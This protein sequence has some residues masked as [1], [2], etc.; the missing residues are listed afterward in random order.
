MSCIL[1]IYIHIHHPILHTCIYWLAASLMDAASPRLGPSLGNWPSSRL[2]QEMRLCQSLWWMHWHGTGVQQE[3]DGAARPLQ[4]DSKTESKW[5]VACLSMY[6]DVSRCPL[7]WCSECCCK[8]CCESCCCGNHHIN[9]AQERASSS[10]L[11]DDVVVVIIK[12]RH[13]C[14]LFSLAIA[15]TTRAHT[16]CV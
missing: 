13:P 8:C 14:M 11:G 15:I 4:P 10:R 1:S 9:V 3:Q 16:H 7:I 6:W 2:K 12:T 5:R